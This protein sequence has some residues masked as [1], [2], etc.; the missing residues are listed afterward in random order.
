MPP[1]S[2][3]SPEYYLNRS[4]SWLAFNRRVLEEAED[5]GNPLL[6]RVKFLA[7]T[8]SNLDEFFEIRIAGLLQHLEEG[9]V[10][11]GPDG[12]TPI[13]EQELVA[14]ATHEFVRGQ[15]D[16]WNKKLLPAL[17]EHGIRVHSLA[18]LNDEQREVVDDYCRN[19]LDAL[20]TPVT[21]DPAHPFPRVIHKA[22]CQALLLRRRRRSAA[23]VNYM[24]VV[25]VP[26]ALPRLVRLPD[27]KGDSFIALADLVGLHAGRMYRGYEILSEGAFRITRNSNLYLQ[28]EESRS[29]LESVRTELHNRRKGDAVRLEIESDASADIVSRL[30]AV[31]ELQDWQVYRTQGPVN[32]SRLMHLHSAVN[33][34][35][36]KFKPFQPREWSLPKGTRDIWGALRQRDVL[37]H[38]PFDSYDSVVS[39]IEAAAQDPAVLSIKQTLYRTN[40]NSPIVEALVQAAAA[41]EV[42]VVVEVKARFDEASNIKWARELE[43]AGVQVFHGLVGLK[44]HCKL[45]LI[46][47]KDPDGVMRRY[48]HL[49][50]GNYNPTTAAFYTDLSLLTANSEMTFAVHNVF[51][52]LTAYSEQPNYNPLLVAPVDLAERVAN[53]IAREADHARAGKPARIIAKVNSL[54]DKNVVQE[55][56]HASQAGVQ[57]DLI[58]RGICSL[59]PGIRGVSDRIQVRSIVGRFLEHSRIYYFQNGG[60]EEIYM[61]S[62]DWMPRNLHERVEVV[63]PLRDAL[64]RER[65][66][67]E[68]LAAYLADNVKSRILQRGGK[69]VREEAKGKTAPFSSQDFL[70]DAAEGKRDSSAIPVAPVKAPRRAVKARADNARAKVT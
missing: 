14:E 70:I 38:H 22:L 6:E 65:V 4:L 24:G 51:N 68:I 12:L 2:L 44:T 67:N 23:N 49:G 36:L 69:Y 21:V 13:D 31:F 17:A 53:L 62:A 46:A 39:F 34:P 35:D 66:K 56:Y 32:L 25:T 18:D 9:Q 27:A 55:L 59:N 48:A 16:C 61:G 10:D 43:D 47:R 58:V 40:D 15:Y 8:A 28:E 37:L 45:T 3:N 60:D 50:T 5:E 7:I 54:L 30:Q 64:L 11:P 57:V 20:L 1:R 26:R 19:E 63:F 29:V 41:K 42:T 33:R 52:F